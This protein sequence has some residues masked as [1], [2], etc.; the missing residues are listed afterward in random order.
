MVL[1]DIKI[2][3]RQSLLVFRGSDQLHMALVVA[4]DTCDLHAHEGIICW[5]RF[6]YIINY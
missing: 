3:V 4:T 1:T 6:L 2:A 5:F